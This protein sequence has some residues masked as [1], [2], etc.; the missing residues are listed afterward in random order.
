MTDTK[1]TMEERIR[2][3]EEKADAL[4]LQL[5]SAVRVDIAP[6]NYEAYAAKITGGTV[7]DQALGRSKNMT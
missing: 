7:C 2:A 3:L 5:K 4:E 1:K 6:I